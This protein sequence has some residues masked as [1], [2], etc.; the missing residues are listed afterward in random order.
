[1]TLRAIDL[2]QP[3]AYAERPEPHANALAR[4]SV[5]GGLDAAFG[6]QLQ[7]R[8]LQGLQVSAGG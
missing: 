5:S 1:M 4:G 6:L 3:R 7:Q 2:V 8:A